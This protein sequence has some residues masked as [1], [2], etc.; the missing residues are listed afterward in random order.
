MDVALI[1]RVLATP[2]TK[3]ASLSTV[4][5][6]PFA[7]WKTV[8]MDRCSA[9]AWG[10]TATRDSDGSMTGIVCGAAARSAF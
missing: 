8:S 9:C 1:A 3:P 10:Q 6:C 2:T 4:T 7:R 5:G